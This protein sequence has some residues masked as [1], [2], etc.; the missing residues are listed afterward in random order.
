[1]RTAEILMDAREKSQ[2][3]FLKRH[4]QLAKEKAKKGES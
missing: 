2:S 1:M 4:S 3:Q